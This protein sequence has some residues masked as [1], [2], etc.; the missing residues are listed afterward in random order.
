M[1]RNP[2]VPYLVL[3]E[4]DSRVSTAEAFAVHRKLVLAGLFLVA[5]HGVAMLF[6]HALGRDMVFGLVPLFDFYEEH[7]VPTYFSSLNLLLTAGLLLLTARLER[8]RGG[9]NVRAWQ[10]LGLGFAFMSLD[11]FAD[12]RI[13]LARALQSAAGGKFEL[14]PFLSVPWTVPVA[15]IVAALAVYMLPFLMR[16]ERTYL[17]H[18]AFA[19]ACFVFASMGL[20]NFEGKHAEL[21]KGTRDLA[22]MLMV[23]LEETMEIF[24]VLYF[25]YFLLRYLRRNYP[26]AALRLGC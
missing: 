20:E 17:A 12:L 23:T 15:L 16:L 1:T 24:S 6:R 19:G 26:G 25:Q 18:F 2:D 14:L 11:E 10:V 8:L 13:I 3:P 4:Q 5:A 9:P 21:T 7:N 22:F